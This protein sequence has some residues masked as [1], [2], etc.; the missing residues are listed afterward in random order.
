MSI[1]CT[2]K[3]RV[4]DQATVR[5]AFKDFMDL[6][7]KRPGTARRTWPGMAK[8]L[9]GEYKNKYPGEWKN[10]EKAQEAFG[11]WFEGA[12]AL[13][14]EKVGI[15][16]EKPSSLFD[17]ISENLQNWRG[18]LSQGAV[19]FIDDLHSI[20]KLAPK[21]YEQFRNLRGAGGLIEQ[22]L[23]RGRFEFSEGGRRDKIIG[24]SWDQI[25]EPVKENYEDASAFLAARTIEE[26]LRKQGKTETARYKQARDA[27]DIALRKHPEFKEFGKEV[28]SY[29]TDL[30]KYVRD[31]GLISDKTY[32]SLI[33]KRAMYAP[34]NRAVEPVMAEQGLGL[35]NSMKPKEAF[36]MRKNVA[37][38][39]DIID[40]ISQ[41]EKNTAYMITMAERNA[42]M[43]TL[44]R[45]L[46]PKAMKGE[47][48]LE[49]V[50]TPKQAKEDL[51]NRLQKEGIETDYFKDLPQEAIDVLMENPIAKEGNVIN[52]WENGKK[53]SYQ[54]DPIIYE[55]LQGMTR[56]QL[57]VFGR[58][59]MGVAQTLREGATLTPA[60][61]A[62]AF[63]RDIPH[64]LVTTQYGIT[65]PDIAKGVMS[66]FKKDAWYD[67]FKRSGAAFS[68]YRSLGRANMAENVSMLGKAKESGK[69]SKWNEMNRRGLQLMEKWRG[70][71]ESLEEAP[72]IAEFRKAIETGATRE[73]AALAAREITLDFQKKGTA[74]YVWNRLVP[75]SNAFIQGNVQFYKWFTPRTNDQGQ[76]TFKDTAVPYLRGAAYIGVPAMLNAAMNADNQKIRDLPQWEQDMFY[77]IDSGVFVDDPKEKKA[78]PIIRIP[79]AQEFGVIMGN[80]IEQAVYWMN[81]K[82]PKSVQ[83][84]VGESLGTL[85]ESRFAVPTVIVPFLEAWSNKT[86]FFNSPLVPLERQALV[87]S[88]QYS[89]RNTELFKSLSKG[90]ARIFGEEG[91]MKNLRTPA[92]ME[93]FVDRWSGSMGRDL[94]RGVDRTLQRLGVFDDKMLPDK[95][96]SD[97]YFLRSFLTRYPSTSAK[98]I[99][100]FWQNYKTQDTYVRTIKRL[101]AEGRVE[102]ARRLYKESKAVKDNKYYKAMSNASKF[103]K[104][105]RNSKMDPARKQEL[106]DQTTL[107]MIQIAKVGNRALKR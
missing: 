73:E 12:D 36:K 81:D 76:Y 105:V 61:L 57:G 9:E 87:T 77:L 17:R 56:K 34:L 49:K 46:A 23:K 42:A 71:S 22:F 84:F 55:G 69:I 45:E 26:D 25:M 72:R 86:L 75:F 85:V 52:V 96:I 31:S 43:R 40:P 67:E 91:A 65:A 58:L 35:S 93:N 64:A 37:S 88:E 13:E 39:Y 10:I 32:D 59:A 83:E 82:D 90:L 38:G 41:I 95:G 104:K 107:Q 44:A 2:P 68:T 74:M 92:A 99:Q 11:K 50:S 54:I 24:K 21:A 19:K 103:I 14:R 101:A 66:A 51:I 15:Y 100:E 33:E 89:D 16:Y 53:N 27:V 62:K 7:I 6:Y 94:L 20:S 28:S 78:A 4:K 48:I 3:D 1:V 80:A 98:P 70:V 106:I 47:T 18:N 8:W 30:L 79:K 29:L 5:N 97:T 63:I 102:E 60:F